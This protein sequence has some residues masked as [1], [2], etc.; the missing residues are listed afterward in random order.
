MSLRHLRN[1]RAD[2]SDYWLCTIFEAGGRGARRTPADRETRRKQNELRRLEDRAD[3]RTGDP[4]GC[5]ER[6]IRPLFRDV[7]GFHL[8]GGEQR[9]HGLFTSAEEE[10]N[11]ARPLAVAW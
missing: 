2:F 9:V 6:F 8:G 1:T 4:D 5:R 10:S 11:G 3:G 7:L